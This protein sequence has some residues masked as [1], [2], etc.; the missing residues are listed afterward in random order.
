M[1]QQD[2]SNH[3]DVIECRRRIA[4][5]DSGLNR[6]HIGSLEQN[7]ETTKD[8]LLAAIDRLEKLQAEAAHD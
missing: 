8:D 3:A 6:L 7:I 4:L 1:G 2:F 5:A